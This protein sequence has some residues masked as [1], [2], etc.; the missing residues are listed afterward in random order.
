M[1]GRLPLWPAAVIPATIAGHALAYAWMGRSLADG[2]HGWVAPAL[3]IGL[4]LLAGCAA[5][6]LANVLLSERATATSSE[7]SVVALWLRLAVAQSALFLAVEWLEGTRIDPVGF[8]VQ[9]AV[10]LIAAGVLA[11]F[12]RFLALCATGLCLPLRHVERRF[13]APRCV[14]TSW[15]HTTVLALAASAGP[16]RFQ[17]PPPRA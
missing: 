8:G 16:A 1:R 3:E 12:A 7:S 6:L 9:I 11:S 4:A 14:R 15:A 5:A 2:R 10:A 17:R 13:S